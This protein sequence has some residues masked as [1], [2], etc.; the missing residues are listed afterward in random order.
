[1]LVMSVF[2]EAVNPGRV[3]AWLGSSFSTCSLRCVR[4]LPLQA[5]MTA[6]ILM[7]MMVR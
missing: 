2:C 3:F 5:I 6:M 1:M 4:M 7:T